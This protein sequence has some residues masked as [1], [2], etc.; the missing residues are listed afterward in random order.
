MN[1]MSFAGIDTVAPHWGAWI[2]MSVMDASRSCRSV[3]PHW[4]AW[5]E[6]STCPADCAASASHPTGVRGLKSVW[7]EQSVARVL[8]APH[9]GAWIE[10]RRRGLGVIIGG[11]H[12]T[13]VRGLK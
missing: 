13:G 8:V 12:P 3:A 11:S 5:I 9:W 4:G 1:T 10:I 7:A 2:E 6:I